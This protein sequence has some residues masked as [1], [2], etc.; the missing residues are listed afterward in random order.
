MGD[1]TQFL[2]KI[3]NGDP[4]A[5]DQLLPL[6]YEELRRLAR[7]RMADEKSGQTLQATALVHEAYL[8]LVGNSQEGSYRDRQHFFA[9][10]A[11]AM[12]RVLVDNARAKMAEKRG[13]QYERVPLF[14]VP[15]PSSDAEVLSL[16]DALEKLETADP[17]KAQ[18]VEL[19]Y[20]AGMTSNEAAEVL[21]IST[22]T[23]ERY[24]AFARAWLQSE[25]RG[26]KKQLAIAAGI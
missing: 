18:L 25:V 2:T 20:F 7:G 23:A 13:G 4:H 16:H 22:A 26:R 11:T 3:E 12:R 9:V 24:W 10:A 21:G 17:Q 15:E 14:D 1:V 5:A 6:V 8:R 19:R